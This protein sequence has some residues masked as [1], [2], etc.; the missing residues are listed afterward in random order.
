MAEEA[1]ELRNRPASAATHG[2]EAAEATSAEA[3]AVSVAGRISAEVEV[4]SVVAGRTLEAAVDTLEAVEADRTLAEEV[5]PAVAVD[6]AARNA[7]P[8]RT[9]QG[10]EEREA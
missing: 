8:R 6:V 3:A 1:T 5:T 9:H 4:T 2:A 10:T 7:A